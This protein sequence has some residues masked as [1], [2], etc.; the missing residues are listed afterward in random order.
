MVTNKLDF[1]STKENPC[2]YVRGDVDVSTMI[3]L[4][5]IQLWLLPVIQL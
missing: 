1:N 2:F 4:E 3:N 5:K